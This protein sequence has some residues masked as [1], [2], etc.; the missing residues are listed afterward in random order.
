MRVEPDTDD[1]VRAVRLRTLGFR[2][3]AELPGG[4]AAV[5]ELDGQDGDAAGTLG[6]TQAFP[7]YRQVDVIPVKLAID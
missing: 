4:G 1:P 3:S 2:I 6:L 7:R 5:I